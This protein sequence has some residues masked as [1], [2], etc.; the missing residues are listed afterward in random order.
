MRIWKKLQIKRV[1]E[2]YNVIVLSWSLNLRTWHV[3]WV[4]LEASFP[5]KSLWQEPFSS[6]IILSHCNR[7]EI[8]CSRESTWSSWGLAGPV[9]AQGVCPGWVRLCAAPAKAT[10]GCQQTSSSS[11]LPWTHTMVSHTP[12]HVCWG[13][14]KMSGGHAVKGGLT[15][16]QCYSVFLQ[17]NRWLVNI[18]VILYRGIQ[19]L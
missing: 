7:H 6:S 4:F 13:R 3:D 1:T 15:R 11:A 14:G 16:A 19:K 18:T 10:A 17:P 8:Q 9:R 5:V 12:G 2:L